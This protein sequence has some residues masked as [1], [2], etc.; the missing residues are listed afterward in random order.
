[1]LLLAA[2]AGWTAGCGPAGEASGPAVYPALTRTSAPPRIELARPPV[3]PMPPTNALLSVIQTELFPATLWRSAAERVTVFGRMPATGLGGPA[4]LAYSSPTGIASLKPGSVIEGAT[5]RENWLLAGFA[6]AEGWTNWDSPWA[7]FLQRRPK[8]VRLDTNGVELEFAGPAGHFSL[9][10]L[11]GSYKPPLRGREVLGPLGLKEK[12]LPSWE[13]GIV[14]ARDPLVR[15]R[16]WAGATR[17]FP[18]YAEDSIRV[19]RGRDTVAF[20]QRFEGID[21]PDEWGTRPI[22]LAPVSPTLGLALGAGQ[23]FPVQFSK[24]PRDFELPTPYGP[25][26]AVPDADAYEMTFSVLRYVNE[27]EAP[28][29][30][31]PAGAPEVVGQALDRLRESARGKFPSAD[32]YDHDHGGMGNFCWAIQGDQWYAKALPYYDATTRSNA[33]ASLGRYFRDEVLVADRFKEREY[34]AGS[35]RRYLILEGPGIGSWGVLGDAGKFAANLLQSVWAYAHYTGDH[36]LVRER[37]PLIRRLFTLPAQTRWVGFGRDEI[38]ELGDKAPSAAAF[39]RLAYLAGDLESYEY[40]CAV[41]ARELVHHY[42]QQRGAARWFRENQPWHSDE[43]LDEE[44]Y[45]TN[46][47]GDLAGWQLDGPA[48]P[49][50]TGERQFDNRWVRFQD[51]DVARFYREHLLA[52]VRTEF[53]RL[54]ARWEAKRAYTDDS[55]ILPSRVRLHS[56]LLQESATNL[57]RIATPDRFRGPPSGV[58]ASSLAMVRARARAAV[59]TADSR[60]AGGGVGGGV[61]P[62]SGGPESVPRAGGGF[63]EDQRA[64][65]AADP[66]VGMEDP[67]RGGVEFRRGARWGCGA[68]GGRDG[69][70]PQLEFGAGGLPRCGTGPGGAIGCGALTYVCSV[71]MRV[72]V[73]RTTLMFEE[74]LLEGVRREAR[75]RGCDLS[76]VVNELLREGLHRKRAAP[77]RRPALPAFAMGRPRA[78]LADRDALEDLM[79]L[80]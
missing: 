48:Y 39:A 28:A 73:K 6:G 33:V 40:G 58:I 57:A 53:A 15:L 65:L 10:P 5:L 64:G 67:D 61:D 41:F 24:I 29:L 2:I 20:R 76:E 42:V 71:C 55:H 44:I 27:T 19:D 11:Y 74:G 52:D 23:K 34:P 59:G 30:P 37:W 63:R 72:C 16:Y 1:V 75:R 46:L 26:F 36:A 21:V 13:W 50:Q 60:R 54:D 47:W 62:G 66:L 35:G 12:K 8:T 68:T 49:A 22:R 14:V 77:T 69:G 79:G 31:V 56:F 43:A 17:W 78:N 25:F 70:A 80:P 4:F 45:L 7:V 9:M 38:A 3:S 18:V 32:R 51:L